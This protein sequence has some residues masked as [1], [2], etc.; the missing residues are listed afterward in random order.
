MVEMSGTR[1]EEQFASGDELQAK[2]KP[3]DWNDYE[4]AARG[5]K[6]TLKIN[7]HLMCEVDDRDAKLACQKGI[8]ATDGGLRSA[9]SPIMFIT[10]KGPKNTAPARRTSARVRRR[11]CRCSNPFDYSAHHK[12]PVLCRR[13]TEGCASTCEHRWGR[14]EWWSSAT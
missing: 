6:I 9:S 12:L 11:I 7:G 4:I 10:G 13:T 5:S 3:N 2:V 1:T 8:I 14:D